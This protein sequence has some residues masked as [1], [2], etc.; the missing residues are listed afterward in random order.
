MRNIMNYFKKQIK[1]YNPETNMA[2]IATP[3]SQSELK[4]KNNIYLKK[5]EK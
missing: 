2:D 5:K 3:I 1:V 4:C